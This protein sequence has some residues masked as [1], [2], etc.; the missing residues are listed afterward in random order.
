MPIPKGGVLF[1][2]NESIGV[3][4]N[5]LEIGASSPRGQFILR[6]PPVAVPIPHIEQRLLLPL[7]DMIR[8]FLEA[9]CLRL[10]RTADHTK[11]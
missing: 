3:S 11:A 8:M 4:V 7:T 9:G 6:Q 1:A 10:D 2:R 5:F